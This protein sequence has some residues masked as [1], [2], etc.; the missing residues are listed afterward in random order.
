MSM[1]PALPR[2]PLTSGRQQPPTGSPAPNIKP[3]AYC[4]WKDMVRQELCLLPFTDQ[5]DEFAVVTAIKTNTGV[6]IS[7][8]TEDH[9]E[10]VFWV[11]KRC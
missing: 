2:H 1:P 6:E 5:E 9:C 3:G 10:F 4:Y 8:D 11:S 7:F